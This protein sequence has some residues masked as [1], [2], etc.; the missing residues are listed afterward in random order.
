VAAP[1]Y[2]PVDHLAPKHYVSP[3]RRA[4]SWLAERPGELDAEQPDGPAM[5]RQGPDQGFALK[6]A[7]TFEDQ[8]HLASGEDMDDVIAGAVAIALKRASL[9]SRAPVRYDIEIALRLWGYLDADPPAALI[10]TRREWF[11]GVGHFH[12]YLELRGIVDAV[13]DASLLVTPA[14]AADRYRA[15]W[16]SQLMLDAPAH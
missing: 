15:G 9:Y 11:E 5:G 13:P 12:H 1:E 3:P 4:G 7:R 6:V 16:E 8:I 14:Q 2:V 10:T